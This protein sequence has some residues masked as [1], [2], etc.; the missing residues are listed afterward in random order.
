MRAVRLSSGAAGTRSIG[1]GV[2]L[3][4]EGVGEE[5]SRE[6]HLDAAV[7]DAVGALA[8]LV[9]DEHRQRQHRHL[10]AP[11]VRLSPGCGAKI[12]VYVNSL[13]MMC[14]LGGGS[15][16]RVRSPGQFDGEGKGELLKVG[17][18]PKTSNV[19]ES[20]DVEREHLAGWA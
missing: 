6:G 12:S 10:R 14:R 13:H 8:D 5:N 17:V 1:R 9:D 2:H 7:C 16:V 11:R 19:E 3:R 15:A 20:Q 4:D 18:A